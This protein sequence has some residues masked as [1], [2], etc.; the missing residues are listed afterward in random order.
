M[1]D[2]ATLTAAEIGPALMLAQIKSSLLGLLI[3]GGMPVS[4][5]I[6]NIVAAERLKITVKEWAIVGLPIGLVL[7][8]AYF[9][10]ICVSWSALP[11]VE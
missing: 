2:N 9:I 1:L 7:M 3:A 11:D 6:P 8:V 4:G 5:N 10:V